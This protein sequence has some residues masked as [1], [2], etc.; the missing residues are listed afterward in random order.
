MIGLKT[1]ML[2]FNPLYSLILFPDPTNP[3]ADRFPYK[4]YILKAIHAGVGRG[5]E[6]DYILISFSCNQADRTA[7]TPLHLA[8]SMIVDDY[9]PVSKLLLNSSASEC[10]NRLAGYPSQTSWTTHN[11]RIENVAHSHS[12]EVIHA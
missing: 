6:R 5:W 9:I 11:K 12:N 7:V 2:T 3:S 4:R 10:L 1:R 8:T